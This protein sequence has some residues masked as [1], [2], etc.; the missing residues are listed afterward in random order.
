MP[1]DPPIP[2]ALAAGCW[3]LAAALFG[4]PQ[5]R[6]L[7]CLA[8][9]PDVEF[10]HPKV[11]GA[12]KGS[13]ATRGNMRALGDSQGSQEAPVFTAQLISRSWVSS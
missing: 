7:A 10:Q 11:R 5:D 4:W 3:L 9:S 13:S 2:E 12:C 8:L 6:V 1:P